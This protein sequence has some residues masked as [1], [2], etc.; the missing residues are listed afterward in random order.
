[1]PSNSA[2]AV[3]AIHWELRQNTSRRLELRME[4]LIEGIVQFR[5]R[6]LPQY[7]QH[8]KDLA[9][10]QMANALLITCSDSQTC[11]RGDLFTMR[12]VGNLVPPAPNA[13]LL[14]RQWQS[15]RASASVGKRRFGRLP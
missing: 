3:I 10:T 15:W 13:P 6:M 9:L 8:F 1:M 2:T 14:A 12:N 5:E 11:W 4:K 7:A